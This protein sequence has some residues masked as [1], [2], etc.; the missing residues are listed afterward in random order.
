MD[1]DPILANLRNLAARLR[2]EATLAD[3]VIEQLQPQ[4]IMAEEP[5]GETVSITMEAGL[6]AVCTWTPT[7]I[8]CTVRGILPSQPQDQ[9]PPGD[10]EID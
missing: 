8:T 2:A 5:P 3:W 9:I 6:V 7:G 4:P 10:V 1:L